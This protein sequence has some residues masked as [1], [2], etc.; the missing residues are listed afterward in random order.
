MQTFTP[1]R[2]EYLFRQY[3]KGNNTSEEREELL[4][5]VCRAGY[6]DHIKALMDEVWQEVSPEYSMGDMQSEKVLKAIFSIEEKPFRK[7]FNIKLRV[8]GA[9]AAVI[10][11]LFGGI[12]FFNSQRFSSIN[13]QETYISSTANE[14]VSSNKKVMLVLGNGAKVTLDSIKNGL[15]SMQGGTSVTKSSN[16]LTYNDQVQGPVKYNTVI[17]PRGMDYQ[18]TLPDGSRVWLNA[19]SSLRF[20]TAFRGKERQVELTGEA[21]F[22]IQTDKDHPFIVKLPSVSSGS[23]RGKIKVL[24]TRFNIMAYADE[25][26]IHTTL[27][28][29]AVQV[30][31]GKE[32]VVLKPG[33]QASMNPSQNPGKIKIKK[34]D[35]AATLAWKDDLFVFHQTKLKEVLRQLTRW[36]DIDIV[37]NGNGNARLNGMISRKASLSA[38]LDMLKITSNL[39][40]KREGNTITV[41]SVNKT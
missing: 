19:A 27:V 13:N 4:Q 7:H 9:A 12:W 38:V 15:I 28:Q 24:G 6:D 23:E 17:T 25:P 16:K 10:A 5:W 29:G 31:R 18:I 35:I 2:L 36:Y 11:L 14:K 8:W 32:R 21:Y 3:F 33:Q 41:L 34:A 30:A 22:E 39:K 20:P 26:A 37:Y 1:S 40:F